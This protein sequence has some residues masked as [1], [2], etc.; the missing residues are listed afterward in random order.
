MKSKLKEAEIL[1]I[2]KFIWSLP[3]TRYIISIN[4]MD[5]S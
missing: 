1:E 4:K 3:G 2:L 5:D